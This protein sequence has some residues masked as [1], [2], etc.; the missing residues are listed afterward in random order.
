[1]TFKI[2]NFIKSNT[3]ITNKH[4]ILLMLLLVTTF[5]GVSAQ[6]IQDRTITVYGSAL[7]TSSDATYKTD[8]TL[9]LDNNY[10]SDSPCKTLEELKAKFFEEVKKLNIDTKRFIIDDLAYVATGYRKDGTI[11]HFETKSKDEI[12]KITTIRMAQVMPSYVQVKYSMTDAEIAKLTKDALKDAKKNAE[13]VAEAAG[14]EIDKVYAISSY[15]YGG[16]SYWT[17]LN[18]EE[19]SFRL[20]VVY[21]LKD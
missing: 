3:K 16:S 7:K 21:K 19:G 17:S 8:I 6:A 13:M 1:M 2:R 10:Y 15:D 5:R 9:S 18:A 12:L 14:E 11:L 20:T 4:F